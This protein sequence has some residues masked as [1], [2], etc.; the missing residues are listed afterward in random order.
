MNTPQY[1]SPLTTKEHFYFFY[2]GMSTNNAAMN[3]V[4][5]ILWG[6]NACISVGFVHIW[7]WTCWIQRW[8]QFILPLVVGSSGVAAGKESAYQCKKTQ[9]WSLGQ[10][11]PL[12]EEM[13]THSSVFA[14]K[15]P[16][17]EDPSGLQ[18]GGLQ[19]VG[20]N[21]AQ[22]SHHSVDEFQRSPLRISGLFL[23]SSWWE[24]NSASLWF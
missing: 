1:A 10:E 17:T 22:H 18:F 9:V 11:D 16:W 23:L 14:W 7:A 21:W 20:H 2:F 12:E 5:H 4:G 6:P 3:T 19:R 15:I 13:A 8:Y 24:C